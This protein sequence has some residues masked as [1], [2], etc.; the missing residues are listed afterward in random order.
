[1][2]RALRSARS[3]LDLPDSVRTA[4]ANTSDVDSQVWLRELDKLNDALR[5]LENLPESPNLFVHMPVSGPS[6]MR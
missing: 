5:D 6:V 1:V 3:V 2:T 4:L